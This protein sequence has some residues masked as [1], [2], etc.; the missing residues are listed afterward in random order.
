VVAIVVILAAVIAAFVFG[1]VGSS[2]TTKTVGLVVKKVDK[3][4][5]S[6]SGFDI[7]WQGGSDLNNL[8]SIDWTVDGVSASSK[9][10]YVQTPLGN[11]YVFPHSPTT[12]PKFKAGDITKCRGLKISGKHIVI[13]GTFFDGNSQVLFDKTF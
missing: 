1:M 7:L 4:S 2:V 10:M 12:T 3:F 8:Q 5:S 6:Q 11:D 9:G 13:I